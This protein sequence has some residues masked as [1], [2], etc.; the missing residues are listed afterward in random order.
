MLPDS[1]NNSSAA[2]SRSVVLRHSARHTGSVSANESTP[3]SIYRAA[4]NASG[5]NCGSV[6][7]MTKTTP[8]S[9]SVA[10]P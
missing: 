4:D 2:Y 9:V 3:Y 8:H 7:G 5:E 6:L 1:N 10:T